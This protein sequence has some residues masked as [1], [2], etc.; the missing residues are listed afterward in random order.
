[1]FVALFFAFNFG[2][3]V[4]CFMC[5]FDWHMSDRLGQFVFYCTS[6]VRLAV[7]VWS[8]NVN[9]SQ[10]KDASNSARFQFFS[11][12]SQWD[13]KNQQFSQLLPVNYVIC[14][15]FWPQNTLSSRFDLLAKDFSHF[16]FN[17]LLKNIITV[18][19]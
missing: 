4:R 13:C 12:N 11:K 7:V 18:N 3:V 10:A 1:M 17:P 19:S 16:K 9:G 2:I 5:S 14:H 8:F 6:L 15:N